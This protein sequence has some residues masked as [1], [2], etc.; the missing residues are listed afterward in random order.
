MSLVEGAVDGTPHVVAQGYR[1]TWISSYLVQGV[2]MFAAVW[3]KRGGAGWQ[4]RH[5]MTQAAFQK[6]FDQMTAQG[7]HLNC[8]SVCGLVPNGY[9]GLWEESDFEFQ[10]FAAMT[11]S[12]Y[13]QK[14]DQLGAEGYRLRQVKGYATIAG[15]HFAAIWDK[16]G[17]SGAWE[18]HHNL[19]TAQFQQTFNQLTSNGFWL[20][21]VSG[22]DNGGQTNY[23]GIF[24]KT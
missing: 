15:P 6:T 9:S 2:Q 20:S 17:G 3:D 21:D 19:T 16:V 7:Y 23:A 8:V 24:Q 11:A 14:F 10:A 4:A 13:Q 22:Y 18:A 12:E 1:P 5:A